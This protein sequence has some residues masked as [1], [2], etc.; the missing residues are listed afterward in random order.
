MYTSREVTAY[1]FIQFIR[2]VSIYQFGESTR[3]SSYPI[4]FSL[5]VLLLSAIS[6]VISHAPSDTYH[7]QDTES[8]TA[9]SKTKQN[10]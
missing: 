7:G 4:T 3:V 8:I 1:F 5:N 10:I 9:R 6:L 2:G